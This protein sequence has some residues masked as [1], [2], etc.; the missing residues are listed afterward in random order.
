MS[1]TDYTF[2]DFLTYLLILAANAD[3]EYKSNEIEHIVHF[4]GDE[5][6]MKMSDVYETHS[7]D[8]HI[9]FLKDLKPQ[10]VGE[11]DFQERVKGALIDIFNSDGEF[12]DIEQVCLKFLEE[13]LK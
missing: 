2:N 12:S 5:S 8:Q 7:S 4:Y 10:F 1:N 6:F 13:E 9:P 11:Q 3:D